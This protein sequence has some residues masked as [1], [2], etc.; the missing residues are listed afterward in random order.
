MPKF[1]A[2]DGSTVREAKKVFVNDG[3]TIREAKKIYAL[4]GSTVRQVFD[5][6]SVAFRGARTYHSSSENRVGFNLHFDTAD[7]HVAGN[8]A[9]HPPTTTG[10]W[11]PQVG[12][13]VILCCNNSRDQSMYVSDPNG[14]TRLDGHSVYGDGGDFTQVSVTGFKDN[15]TTYDRKITASI[16]YR[17]LTGSN[18]TID[19]KDSIYGTSGS[20]ADTAGITKCQGI[21]A[22]GSGTG[23]DQI[24]MVALFRPTATGGSYGIASTQTNDTPTPS[25]SVLSNQTI[26]ASS[27]DAVIQ[28]AFAVCGSN[29]STAQTLTTATNANTVTRN[30]NNSSSSLVTVTGNPD[31]NTATA[32]DRGRANFLFSGSIRITAP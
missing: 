20:I 18:F 17:L 12:D 23:M 4:D 11:D 10:T 30:H 1:F 21:S 14:Y 13:I 19:T 16:H 28:Y 32:V 8:G 26:T 27:A 9:L 2:L 5:S 3:G 31:A 25:A 6:F 15:V 22:A 24:Y 29:S 7:D